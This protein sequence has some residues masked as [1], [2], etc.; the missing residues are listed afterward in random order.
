MGGRGQ[1]AQDLRELAG[2]ELARSTGAVTE[3]RQTP[4]GHA[5][6]PN[7]RATR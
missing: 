6:H 7:D 4:V 3:L 5:P 1:R 2:G